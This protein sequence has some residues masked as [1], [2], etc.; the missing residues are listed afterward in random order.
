MKSFY[1]LYDKKQSNYWFS[2]ML[3]II[4]FIGTTYLGAKLINYLSNSNTYDIYLVIYIIFYLA[5]IVLTNLSFSLVKHMKRQMKIF[6][7]R[8]IVFR[9]D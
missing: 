2:I 8:I 7:P 9:E 3:A 1:L 4:A 5:S 6:S